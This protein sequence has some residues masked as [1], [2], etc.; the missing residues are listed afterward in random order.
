M[1]F[2]IKLKTFLRMLYMQNNNM[3]SSTG[4]LAAVIYTDTLQTIIMVVGSFIL[5]GFGTSVR[6]FVIKT[7]WTL[8]S[9][10]L[11]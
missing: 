11:I 5:M 3:V 6:F 1:T 4:G 8:L 7:L 9:D 10:Y 2:F